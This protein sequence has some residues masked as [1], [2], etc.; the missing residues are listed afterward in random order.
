[1][2]PL[3]IGYLPWLAATLLRYCVLTQI[4]KAI[5]IRRFSKWL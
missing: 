2:Q 5:Y 3:P 1:M 4:I